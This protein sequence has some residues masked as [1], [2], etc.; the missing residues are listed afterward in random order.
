MRL[1]LVML[2]LFAALPMLADAGELVCPRGQRACMGPFGATCYA[3]SSGAV[4]SGGLVCGQGQRS[5]GGT[6]YTPSAGQSCQFG[7]VC[8][9]G[10][11]VCGSGGFARCYTPS[12]GETCN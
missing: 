7:L 4:C 1:R 8:G 9:Q 6:C 3:P 5:C 11:Q 2:F 12:A 10:Q